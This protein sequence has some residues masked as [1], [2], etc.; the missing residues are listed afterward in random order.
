MDQISFGSSRRGNP[1]EGPNEPIAVKT[2]LGW[3]LSGPLQGHKPPE[4]ECHINFVSS[5]MQE[6]HQLEECLHKLWDL[7][8]IGIR[9]NDE[10]RTNLVD[11]IAFTGDRYSVSLP[12]KVGHK[13]LPSN[14]DICY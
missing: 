14:Y 3:V 9:E 13:D 8:S 6:K 7:D 2:T 10:V 12:W 11:D 4:A 5:S 1:Y